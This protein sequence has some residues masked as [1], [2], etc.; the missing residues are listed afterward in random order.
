[1]KGMEVRDKLKKEF[2]NKNFSKKIS[3]IDNYMEYKDYYTKCDM[4]E[5]KE[6]FT[7]EEFKNVIQISMFFDK[8]DLFFKYFNKIKKDEDIIVYAL[9]NINLTKELEEKLI[10]CIDEEVIDTF[11]Y[12]HNYIPI[13]LLKNATFKQM[14]KPYIHLLDF[15]KLDLEYLD[16]LISVLPKTLVKS[17]KKKNR[18]FLLF[19][20]DISN[21]LTY[22]VNNPG[23]RILLIPSV[24]LKIKEFFNTCLLNDE[25]IVKFMDSIIVSYIKEYKLSDRYAIEK[26]FDTYSDYISPELVSLVILKYN[27]VPLNKIS[28]FNEDIKKSILNLNYLKLNSSYILE[29]YSFYK[30][31]K[32]FMEV[33]E[34]ACPFYNIL[35]SDIGSLKYE[36]KSYSFEVLNK[37]FFNDSIFNKVS[38]LFNRT[39]N[40]DLF[41]EK[42]KHCFYNTKFINDIYDL[43]PLSIQIPSMINYF[44]FV[45]NYRG[46]ILDLSYAEPEELELLKSLISLIESDNSINDYYTYYGLLY[47]T[48]RKYYD[49]YIYLMSIGNL[50]TSVIKKLINIESQRLGFSFEPK[51]ISDLVSY[52]E[53][54]NKYCEDNIKLN[55]TI[56]D[57]K[58]FILIRYFR[59]KYFDLKSII[60]KYSYDI[61]FQDS[62]VKKIYKDLQFI[63]NSVNKKELIDYVNNLDYK[64]DCYK[65][66][67]DELKEII[68]GNYCKEVEP[69][70]KLEPRKTHDFSDK[71]FKLFIHVSLKSENKDFNFN[72][73][74][75]GF[76]YGLIGNENLS[77]FRS[78]KKDITSIWGYLYAYHKDIL[79]VGPTDLYS[80]ETL[81]TE[82]FYDEKNCKYYPVNS[83]LN[84]CYLVHNEIVLS[85]RYKN[86]LLRPQAIISIDEKKSSDIFYSWHYNVPLIFIDS[87]RVLE[88]EKKKI[89]ISIDLFKKNHDEVL[90]RNIIL[91]I[92]TLMKHYNNDN[93]KGRYDIHEGYNLIIDILKEVKKH[94][95]KF[96]DKELDFLL[97]RNL[98]EDNSMLMMHLENK[99]IIKLLKLLDS[100]RYGDSL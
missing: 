14:L 67:D 72:E 62:K 78:L 47:Y 100:I 50:N 11:I 66:V 22:I 33:F 58:N 16:K 88:R 84:N 48:V 21:H 77:Y 64:Y 40:N 73:K 25:L 91:K 15:D 29:I 10:P 7:L 57:V 43:F 41:K 6:Y 12:I 86:K 83:L 52:D 97:K 79:M 18:L 1:M 65:N 19:S 70:Y 17:F 95:N 38:I 63:Y 3:N 54:L 92:I 85:S 55:N 31:D 46:I 98:F 68:L 69:L 75:R 61:E 87:E 56:Y 80:N 36:V 93:I 76:C 51:T 34:R 96:D 37:V 8:Y 71:D 32:D 74:F 59:I 4:D 27:Y 39:K 94:K 2:L 35:T 26:F 5:F 60:N 53:K 45:C 89:N 81:N 30:N 99:E 9:R 42:T 44:K 23:N 24:E 49:L 13:N 82:F 28:W 90:G 20:E